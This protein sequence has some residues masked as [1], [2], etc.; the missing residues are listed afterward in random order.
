M[1]HCERD[2]V[3]YFGRPTCDVCGAVW[4][5]DFG[6]WLGYGEYHP[7]VRMTRQVADLKNGCG[8]LATMTPEQLRIVVA[9]WSP[10]GEAARDEY[11]AALRDYADKHY[12]G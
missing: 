10:Y 2:A 7:I 4:A 5:A 1:K 9:T 3:H 8:P 12:G 11:F 6:V